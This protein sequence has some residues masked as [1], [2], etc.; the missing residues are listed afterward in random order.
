MKHPRNLAEIVEH[1][2]CIGC[3]L[4]QSI[5]GPE[6]VRMTMV[7]PP[8]R[9]RPRILAPLDDNTQVRIL[10]ACPGVTI[11]QPL[12]PRRHEAATVD[13]VFG[14][15]FNVW[16]GHA[17]DPHV[18][19]AASSGGALSALAIFLLQS[20]KVD[21]ILHLKASP[22]QPM[23]SVAHLSFNP[24]QVMEATGSR[25]GPA[26]PLVGFNEALERGQRF[27]VVGKPCDVSGVRNMRRHDPRVD[28]LVRYTMAFSCGTF[29]DLDCSRAM[30]ERHGIAGEEELSLFRYRGYGCPGPTRA[31][32]RDGRVVD[33][34]YLDFWYGPWGWTH[35]FRCKIC[36]DPTGEMTDISVAD[37][38]PGGAP[39]EEEWGGFNL[40]VSRTIKGNAL[41]LEAIDANAVTV[42]RSD[43]SAMH[44]CQPHQVVKIQGMTARLEAIQ[45]EGALGPRFTNLR[46]T[47]AAA[48]RDEAFRRSHRE[49]T[50]ER[51]R[52]G[53]NREPSTSA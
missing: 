34:P 13:T 43:I 16:R 23:R 42:E 9:M 28:A 37:A 32:T 39:T 8:G 46:L 48:M 15:W 7:E 52:K 1:G 35:Q 51:I 5:A 10:A 17:S 38:W 30:L 33:E 4:C 36:P 47:D 2:L 18:H 11:D 50:R 19:H 40:F 45:Q 14:P 27:A 44:E 53:V 41:M 3:G 24:E 29:G 26:A 20:R 6:R 22:T 12:E 31:V 49:G 25:Y 21:F